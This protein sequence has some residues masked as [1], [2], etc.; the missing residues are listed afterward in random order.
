MTK[1][2]KFK[3]EEKRGNRLSTL[4]IK[5]IKS[6]FKSGK[7]TL[8]ISK[9]MKINKVTVR[10]HTDPKF[11][12]RNNDYHNKYISTRRQNDPEF[13]KKL[14][15]Y[16]VRLRRIQYQKYPVIKERHKQYS[17]N[18]YKRLKTTK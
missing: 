6:L 1:Y 15:K 16:R 17:I 11:K 13:K 8:Q 3:P 9:E 7:N 5:Q 12:K 18:Q 4:Q 2:P 14:D 10:R